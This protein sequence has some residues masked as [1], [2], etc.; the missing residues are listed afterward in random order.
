MSIT[1]ICL[2][3]KADL[4]NKNLKFGILKC[5]KCGSEYQIINKIP[6][7]L[8]DENDFYR[9]RRIF[10]RMMDFKK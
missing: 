3:C 2:S 1:I 8:D 6:I 9:Y 7:I 10:K 5:D 4:K